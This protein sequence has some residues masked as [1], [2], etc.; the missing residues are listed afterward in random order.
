VNERRVDFLSLQVDSVDR[1]LRSAAQALRRDQ[2]ATGVV[3]AAVVGKLQLEAAGDLRREMGSVDV[4]RAALAQLQGQ[5][6][7]G[8]IASRQLSAFPA[9]LKSPGIN[10]LIGQLSTLETKRYTLLAKLTPA[11]P[12]VVATTDAIKNLEAQ[13]PPLAATYGASLD[14]QRAAIAQQLDSLQS[15]VSRLP[16]V[17]ETMAQD[18]RQVLQL[19]QISA[20]LNAQLVEARVSA[21]GEGGDV[22]PLDVAS[23]PRERSFPKQGLTLALGGSAGCV[24]GLLLAIMLSAYGRYVPDARAIERQTGLPALALDG[25]APLLLG[26]AAPHSILLIPL[27]TAADTRGV[28]ERLVRTA[29]SRGLKATVLDLSVSGAMLPASVEWTGTDEQLRRLASEFDTVVVRL[30]ALS[31]ET[32]AGVLRAD[33]PVVLVASAGRVERARLQD[34]IGSLNRMAVPCAGV[35]LSRAAGP[36]GCS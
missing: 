28:A 13:L 11:D 17:G 32:T 3:D 33:R 10:E 36:I 2:E 27:D 23:P 24:A 29:L 9:F 21:I 22:R 4:E 19:T 15:T 18:Q 14:R 8:N 20:A 5:L 12:E 31:H 1:Q 25:T 7:S 35:V 34:A 26:G 6:A 30:P 16:A